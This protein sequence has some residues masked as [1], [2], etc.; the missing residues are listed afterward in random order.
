MKEKEEM[1]LLRVGM[2]GSEKENAR[3][4]ETQKYR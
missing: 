4:I 2:R 3:M 1:D